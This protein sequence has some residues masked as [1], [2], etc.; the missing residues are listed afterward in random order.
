MI[1]PLELWPV[2]STEL[3]FGSST[4]LAKVAISRQSHIL[5]QVRRPCSERDAA[6]SATIG[7]SQILYR[8]HRSDESGLQGEFSIR[9]TSTYAIVSA[10]QDK[11]TLLPSPRNSVE[12]HLGLLES[13]SCN[14]LISPVE[15]KVD[16]VLS[17]RDMRHFNVEGSKSSY[18]M[19]SS[20]IM[21]ITR[22]SKRPCR[23]RSS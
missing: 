7:G 4:R 19:T 21:S 13:T 15:S 20:S 11:Q 9:A 16:H 6:K 5:V 2:Q 8:C 14:I 1:L 10:N 22:R 12:G 3:H 17:K 23:T 18:A